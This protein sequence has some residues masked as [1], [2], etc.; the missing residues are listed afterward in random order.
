M[1]RDMGARALPPPS[2]A[3]WGR[4]SDKKGVGVNAGAIERA[5]S[6][7]KSC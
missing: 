3:F 1:T 5:W 6:L 7:P 2:I 4:R